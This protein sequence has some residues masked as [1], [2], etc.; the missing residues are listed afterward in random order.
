MFFSSLLLL[1][2]CTYVCFQAKRTGRVDGRRT[3]STRRDVTNLA[4]DEQLFADTSSDE[5]P[6]WT[7]VI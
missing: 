3:R 5:D 4:D 6:E 1:F 7:P 2:L